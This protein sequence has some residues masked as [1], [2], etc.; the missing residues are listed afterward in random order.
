M[1]SI[2]CR[3]CSL[4]YREKQGSHICYAIQKELGRKWQPKIDKPRLCF[5]YSKR[6]IVQ[7]NT[8]DAYACLLAD[9]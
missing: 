4:L 3:N 1:D 8:F 2:E 7:P 9:K 6:I 5:Y